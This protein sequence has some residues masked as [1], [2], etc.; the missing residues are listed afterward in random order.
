MQ[1]H[2]FY[3]QLGFNFLDVQDE[4]NILPP[5]FRA[6]K[7]KQERYFQKKGMRQYLKHCTRVNVTKALVIWSR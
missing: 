1:E 6:L 7:S 3:P 5:G 2:G 4:H